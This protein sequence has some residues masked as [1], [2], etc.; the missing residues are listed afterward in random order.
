VSVEP[1]VAA[2]GA[3]AAALEYE[4]LPKPSSARRIGLFD[5]PPPGEVDKIIWSKK[6]AK[7]PLEEQQHYR[8]W[9]N[10]HLWWALFVGIVLAI[11]AF[12]IWFRFQ[13]PVRMLPW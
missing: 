13:H 5:D 4:S 7:L 6:Y 11:Y 1:V 8:G 10:W 3:G 12:F 9:K 2:V